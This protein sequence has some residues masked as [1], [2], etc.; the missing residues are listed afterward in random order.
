MHE[1]DVQ[2]KFKLKVPEVLVKKQC[3]HRDAPN[4]Y[5]KKMFLTPA[6]TCTASLER[7]M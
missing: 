2:E 4:G 6:S 1:I 7:C 3:N 5:S